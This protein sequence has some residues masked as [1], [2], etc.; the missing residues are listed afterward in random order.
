MN[1][2]TEQAACRDMPKTV[3]FPRPGQRIDEARN[4]CAR[5][6]VRTECLA[7]ANEHE[8]NRRGLVFGYRGGMTPEGR[9]AYRR[10]ERA[11]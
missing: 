6:P 7:E 1:D 5:C 11:S 10:Q 3:F 2:W 9:I 4:A 8:I